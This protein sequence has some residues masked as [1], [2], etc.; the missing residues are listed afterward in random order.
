MDASTEEGKNNNKNGI[1]QYSIFC[2]QFYQSLDQLKQL[3]KN[4]Q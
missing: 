2:Y 3:L 1:G 4:N